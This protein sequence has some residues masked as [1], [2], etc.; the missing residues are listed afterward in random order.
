MIVEQLNWNCK[1]LTTIVNEHVPQHNVEQTIIYEEVLTSVNEHNGT[2]FFLD[3]LIGTDKTFL[4]NTIVVK[5]RSEENIVI[6]VA[7]YGIVALLLDVG[8]TTHST[9]KLPIQ[10][11]EASICAIDKTSIMQSFA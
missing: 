5:L 10:I 8:Q 7:S 2:T 1:D 9:F 3:G 4:Y 11:N 6:C